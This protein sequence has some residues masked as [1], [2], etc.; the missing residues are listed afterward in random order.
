MKAKTLEYNRDN[1]THGFWERWWLRTVPPHGLA[2]TRICLGLFMLVYAGLYIPHITLMFSSHG[3]SLPL[4][5]E[6]LPWFAPVLNPPSPLVAHIVYG[7]FMLSFV[8]MTL[9]AWFRFSTL[10]SIVLSLYHWQ[11]QLHMFPT[12]YNRILLLTFIVMLFSGAHRTWSYDQWR[13]SGSPWDWEPVSILA[14]RFLTIQITGTFL[15]VSLQKFWLPAWKGGEILAYSFTSRW[16]TPL[17]W[18]YIRLPFTL[19]HYDWLVHIVKWVQPVAAAGMWIPKIRWP[20][21]IFLSGFLIKVSVMLSIWWFVFIIPASVLFWNQEA[22]TLWCIARS[23]G[24]I[25]HRQVKLDKINS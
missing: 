21:Y 24:R 13:R 16:A 1:S 7:V 3:L 11:L 14:Q 19:N 9:G 17:A 4:Y 18:W 5:I 22:F 25:A 12:S 23:K 8:G 20:S 15:G 10:V 2:F 6:Q